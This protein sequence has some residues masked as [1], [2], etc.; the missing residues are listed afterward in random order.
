MP[1][2]TRDAASTRHHPGDPS[3]LAPRRAPAPAARRR[4]SDAERARRRALL[5][6]VRLADRARQDAPDARDGRLA[7]L[8]ARRRRRV[9]RE[10]RRDRRARPRRGVLA[11]AEALI[12][13]P[14][15]R[16]AR[17]TRSRTRS[18]PSSPPA[19][20]SCR[21]GCCRARRRPAHIAARSGPRSTCSSRRAASSKGR[22]HR[23]RPRRG[24]VPPRRL[25][26]PDLEHLDGARA[27]RTSRSRWP[28]A[29]RSRPTCSA[30]TSSRGARAATAASATTRPRARTSS[31]RSS[32]PRRW[33]TRAR[34]GEAYFQASLIAER[35]GHWVLARTYAERAKAAYEELTDRINV[36]QLLNNLGGLDFLLGK[37]EEAIALL[38]EAFAIALEHGVDDGRRDDDL[39]ARADPICA[40]ASREGRG[41][42]PP[43]AGAARR[44]RGP[45]RRDRQRAARA[46]PLAARAG[47]PR[48]G[49]GG[50]RPK[51]RTRSPSFHPA[52]IEPRHGWR[53]AISRAARRR[54][55]RSHPLP[56][57][58]RDSPRLQVLSPERSEDCGNQARSADQQAS[59]SADDRL[60][61]RRARRRED[62]SLVPSRRL[63][64][65]LD[66]PRSGARRFGR[67][68]APN[69]TAPL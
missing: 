59:V 43:R 45:P 13:A 11:R 48:R 19:R 29:R 39:V 63:P 17:S 28:S 30:P 68:L 51:R 33:T 3:G 64:G 26:L 40:P 56:A 42:G 36:G 2:M 41:A 54:P 7:R 38:K 18:P 37:P 6:G 66:R 12:R 32:S 22:L 21:C 10:R 34:S 62:R 23:S 65:R 5:E 8:A 44:A 60:C 55:P 57:R 27:L 50:V 35:E 31:A 67:R 9:P 69:R 58:S 24:P 15:L 1:P 52:R 46:R 20:S 49:R 16:R 47:P 53:R 25:P 14:R 4:R 61:G